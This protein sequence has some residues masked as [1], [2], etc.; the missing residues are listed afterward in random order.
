MQSNIIKS[1]P[2]NK[3]ILAFDESL[4][5]EHIL[6]ESEKLKMSLFN[7]K[8]IFVIYDKNNEILEK[9]SKAAPTDLSKQ[10]FE[11]LLRDYMFIKEQ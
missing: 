9:G 11:L 4:S 7:N 6:K 10:S 3:V 5:L 8:D 1:L 2:V